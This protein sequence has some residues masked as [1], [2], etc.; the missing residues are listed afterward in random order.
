MMTLKRFAYHPDGTLGV[1]H[2]PA[3]KLHTFYTIERPWLNNKPWESCIPE[4]EYAMS[5]QESPKFDWCYE[6][7][8]VP[9]RSDILLHVANFPSDVHGCIGLGMGPMADRIAVASSRAAM[10]AFHELTGGGKWRI[11]IVHAKHAALQSL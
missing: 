8:G 9:S 1:L 7:E 10:T 11:K 2:V 6:I 3:Q 4:G 5:W